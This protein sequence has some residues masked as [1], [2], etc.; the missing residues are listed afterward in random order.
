M[1]QNKII[2]LENLVPLRLAAQHLLPTQKRDAVAIVEHLGA[3]QAQD[4]PMAFEKA[5]QR[6]ARFMGLPLR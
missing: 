2:S 1:P 3:M 4:L 5:C 6:Y